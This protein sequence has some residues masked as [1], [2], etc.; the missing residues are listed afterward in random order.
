MKAKKILF[1]LLKDKVIECKACRLHESR[2]GVVFGKGNINADLMII[3]GWPGAAEDA[4]DEPFV[5]KAGK[6][7]YSILKYYKLNKEDVFLTNAVCC[8]TPENR[9]PLYEEEVA[10]CRHRLGCQIS[11]IQPKLIVGLGPLAAQ[12][13]MGYNTCKE[14]GELF[15]KTH[16]INVD[17]QEF[18]AIMSYDPSYL[19]EKS[20][21]RSVKTNAQRHWDRIVGF[22]DI[23]S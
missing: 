11:I 9:C 12:A 1:K 22:L 21:D 17:D 18:T 15:N 13:L 14:A 5:G 20:D 7:L 2:Q 8:S 23:K 4:L 16:T 6:K 10:M 3:G 19:L